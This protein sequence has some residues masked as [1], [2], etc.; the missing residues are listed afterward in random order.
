MVRRRWPNKT[1]RASRSGATRPCFGSLTHVDRNVTVIHN[2][3]L[4]NADVARWAAG[5]TIGGRLKFGAN[6]EPLPTGGLCP[7]AEDGECDSG[8][9]AVRN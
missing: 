7:W 8:R 9:P 4:P 5:V 2:D 6:A 1:V 3:S